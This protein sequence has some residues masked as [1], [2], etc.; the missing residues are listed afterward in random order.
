MD[1]VIVVG[2]DGSEGSRLALRWALDE[3]IR[4]GGVVRAVAAWSWDG[5][6]IAAA[7]HVRSRKP[8]TT[9]A[10]TPPANPAEARE[11][12]T[13]TCADEVADAIDESGVR[14]AVTCEVV[15]GPAARVLSDAARGARL[16]VLGSHGHSRLYHSVLGSVSEECIHLAT[17]PVVVVPLPGQERP[18][19]SV[20]RPVVAGRAH[21][22]AGSPGPDRPL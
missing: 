1:N 14:G 5:R 8:G 17:C 3:A 4:T 12:A 13:R 9:A 18:A 15:E 6:E 19:T 21:V 10:A 2:V 11:R 22:R 20:T 7:E 16:L